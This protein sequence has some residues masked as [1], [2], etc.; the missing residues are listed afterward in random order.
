MIFLADVRHL[1]NWTKSHLIH[2]FLVK[3]YN[4]RHIVQRTLLSF[5]KGA[6]YLF[7]TPW[8]VTGFNICKITK[9]SM[10]KKLSDGGLEDVVW[11]CFFN[12]KYKILHNCVGLLKFN[13]NKGNKRRYVYEGIS[14]YWKVYTAF[15]NLYF[16][17]DYVGFRMYKKRCIIYYRS[18]I[19]Y[20]I[21]FRYIYNLDINF[22]LVK[23][24]VPIP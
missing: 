5:L 19:R 1:V 12:R 3:Q 8:V 15:H 10:S 22:W 13:H 20:I 14:P 11:Y 21:F 7:C 23:Q 16:Y 18:N 6:I 17:Y 2:E 24:Y 4:G 9:K